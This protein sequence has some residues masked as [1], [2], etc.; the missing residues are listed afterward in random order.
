MPFR[1]SAPNRCPRIL[2]DALLNKEVSLVVYDRN[3]YARSDAAAFERSCASPR[4]RG[5]MLPG[6]I[7]DDFQM[8]PG[9]TIPGNT[10]TWVNPDVA[11]GTG[12]LFTVQGTLRKAANQKWHI[13]KTRPVKQV[14]NPEA[15]ILLCMRNEQGQMMPV[16]MIGYFPDEPTKAWERTLMFRLANAEVAGGRVYA[17]SRGSQGGALN[18]SVAVHVETRDANDP[19]QIGGAGGNGT[20]PPPSPTSRVVSPDLTGFYESTD[21]PEV[22]RPILVQI[23]QAGARIAG[24]VTDVPEGMPELVKLAAIPTVVDTEAT[25][26]H[27]RRAVFSGDI[28]SGTQWPITWW[29]GDVDPDRDLI[30]PSAQAQELCEWGFGRISLIPGS[31]QGDDPVRLSVRFDTPHGYRAG[32][33][34]QIRAH[35]EVAARNLDDR[36]GRREV[37]VRRPQWAHRR[38]QASGVSLRGSNAANA[39]IVGPHG[40]GRSTAA[41]EVGRRNPG[42]TLDVP[43]TFLSTILCST[44]CRHR[45][46]AYVPAEVE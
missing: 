10:G 11:V 13:Q 17:A 5:K 18:P 37:D 36:A 39:S 3:L 27:L 26:Y 15:A 45:P 19:P 22:L 4:D 25:R 23:N 32:Q 28:N 38:V 33:L 8:P 20:F 24:W 12:V 46:F 42:P 43:G 30:E 6:F 40:V 1:W 16:G 29:K 14:A 34:L 31:G 2:P 41:S 35:I 21:D 7:T 44:S 9:S